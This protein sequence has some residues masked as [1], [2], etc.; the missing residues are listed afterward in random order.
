MYAAAS[1]ATAAC[2]TARAPV[3]LALPLLQQPRIRTDV[4]GCVGGIIMPRHL[5]GLLSVCLT[6]GAILPLHHAVPE[7]D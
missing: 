2:S 4:P 1:L 6:L 7:L 3:P 5:T